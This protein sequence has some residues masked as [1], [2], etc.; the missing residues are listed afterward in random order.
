MEVAIRY[1]TPRD[2]GLGEPETRRDFNQR[3]DMPPGPE[4]EVPGTATHLWDWFWRLSRR[5]QRSEAGPQPL[6]NTEIDAWIRLSTTLVRPEEV[7]ILIAMDDTYLA[8]SSRE[9]RQDRERAQDNPSPEP[10][11]KQL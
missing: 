8:A 9:I 4:A 7:Q 6:S 1:D 11:R 2:F 5:R 10:K 3:F